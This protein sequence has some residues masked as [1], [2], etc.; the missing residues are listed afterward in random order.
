MSKTA[1]TN[2]ILVI[3]T[4]IVA[5]F[6]VFFA[7]R[8][9][10]LLSHKY[11]GVGHSANIPTLYV[12]GLGGSRR[13]TNH[14]ATIASRDGGHR[15]LTVIVK[16][17]GH[18]QY[19][20]S[21][22]PNVRKPIVQVIFQKRYTP[23]EQQVNWFHQVLLTLK[24]KYHVHSYNAVGHSTGAVT[25]LETV[26]KYNHKHGHKVPRLRR[27][28]SIAG[29]YDGILR[30]NDIAN[31]NYVNYKGQPVIYKP[32][33]KWFPAYSTLVKDAKHFPKGVSVLNIYGNS[34][35]HTNSDGVVSVASA[36]SLKYLIYKRTRNYEEIPVYGYNGQH[37]RLHHNIFVDHIIARFI[38]DEN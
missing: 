7:I 28:V 22:K 34:N 1:R 19:K 27:F 32:A 5:F 33:N 36:K 35:R 3:I 8:S 38:F 16:K 10:R 18:I 13:S 25:I 26:S 29:P 12:H 11:M 4:I 24:H 2:I 30:L 31:E 9:D 15:T 23:V 6:A 20:G 37:S 21:L 17:D 14:L